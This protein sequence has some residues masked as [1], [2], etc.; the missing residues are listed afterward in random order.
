MRWRLMEFRVEIE[1]VPAYMPPLLEPCRGQRQAF[2]METLRNGVSLSF[3][4]LSKL[5]LFSVRCNVR[6]G[7]SFVYGNDSNSWRMLPNPNKY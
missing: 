3:R 5:E 1:N 2:A 4:V 7:M 6:S